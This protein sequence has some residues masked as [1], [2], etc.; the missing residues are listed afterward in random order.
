MK[1]PEKANPRMAPSQ[2]PVDLGLKVFI[3]PKTVFTLGQDAS[4][5]PGDCPKTD[6]ADGVT[7]RENACEQI[8]RENEQLLE[9]FIALMRQRRRASTTIN[10]HYRN[11]D[12]FI[13]EYLAH[14]R[15]LRAAEGVDEID[16]YFGDWFIRKAMWSTPD[17][18]KKT[19]NSLFQ[20]Y[21]FLA[22][23]E[24]ITVLQ[25]AELKVLIMREMPNWQARCER[26]NNTDDDDWRGLD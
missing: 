8:H 21:T 23:L 9:R 15:G 24:M 2:Q 17:T 5:L 12:F 20:F 26:Y 10:A 3:D 18:I 1:W 25:L 6:A 19:A 7:A 13:N 11:I 4:A 14:G 22:A 16:E